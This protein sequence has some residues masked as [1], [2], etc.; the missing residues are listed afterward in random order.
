MFV[1]SK[2]DK[3]HPKRSPESKDMAKTVFEILQFRAG[4]HGSQLMPAGMPVRSGGDP[5]WRPVYAGWDAG[6]T[7][8]VDPRKSAIL[9]EKRPENPQIGREINGIWPWE[10]KGSKINKFSNRS[11]DQNLPKRTRFADRSKSKLGLFLVEIFEFLK[12]KEKFGG[13]SWEAKIKSV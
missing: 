6:L 12:N 13:N 1:A 9:A 8:F 11:M 7:H 5:A 10:R 2:R 3:E 4:R